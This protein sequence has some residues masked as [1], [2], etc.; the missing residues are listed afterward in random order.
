MNS[1]YPEGGPGV[2]DPDL[3][4]TQFFKPDEAAIPTSATTEWFRL[5]GEQ[6]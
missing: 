1:D 4:S 6:C 3:D 5:T 2:F